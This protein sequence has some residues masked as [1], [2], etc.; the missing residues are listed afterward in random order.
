MS[1]F[2]GRQ[3]GVVGGK[4]KEG[5]SREGQDSWEAFSSPP[6]SQSVKISQA[7]TLGQERYQ[8]SIIS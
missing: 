7:L 4:G 6:K 5:A 2:L 3:E 1:R 8:Y